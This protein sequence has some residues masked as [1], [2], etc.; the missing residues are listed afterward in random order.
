MG[1]HSHLEGA[2]AWRME[3][4]GKGGRRREGAHFSWSSHLGQQNTKR[5]CQNLVGMHL[6]FGACCL[7]L[8]TVLYLPPTG[9][10]VAVEEES[11]MARKMCNDKIFLKGA[12]SNVA[13][14]LVLVGWSVGHWT[15]LHS[16][17]MLSHGGGDCIGM[18]RETLLR[19][20]LREET[21][22][23]FKGDQGCCC[24]IEDAGYHN[25][26]SHGLPALL[27]E[28]APFIED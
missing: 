25:G 19:G 13:C 2:V 21:L 11:P 18:T 23:C 3:F 22:S 1:T 8:L 12:V 15:H 14:C 17:G 26:T 28:G 24:H 4:S 27:W 16:D 10:G 6:I 9:C 7:D 20:V 5:T